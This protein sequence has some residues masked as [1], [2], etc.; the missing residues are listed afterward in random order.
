[1]IIYMDS[2]DYLLPIF[3]LCAFSVRPRSDTAVSR[4]PMHGLPQ[5]P[6]SDGEQS[7]KYLPT[8]DA[9]ASVKR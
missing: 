9:Y 8:H 4:Y 3:S 6:L 7:P 5:F 2:R 1:M